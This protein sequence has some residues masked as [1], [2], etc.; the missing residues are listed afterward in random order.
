MNNNI[1]TIFISIIGPVILPNKL[2]SL[3]RAELLQ[4]FSVRIRTLFEIRIRNLLPLQFQIRIHFLQQ[5]L[6]VPA[7]CTCHFSAAN[8][9]LLQQITSFSLLFGQSINPI[10]R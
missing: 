9:K 4:F 1:F 5:S 3:H 10:L 8:E 2:T 7:L 6:I